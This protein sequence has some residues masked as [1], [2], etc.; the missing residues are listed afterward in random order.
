[1][2]YSWLTEEEPLPHHRVDIENDRTYFRLKSTWDL[3]KPKVD[4]LPADVYFGV[5]SAYFVL[6]RA[7]VDGSLPDPSPKWET[8]GWIGTYQWDMLI[9]MW[10]NAEIRKTSESWSGLDAAYNWCG[11]NTD[12]PNQRSEQ[13]RRKDEL[14]AGLVR[15]GLI[16]FTRTSPGGRRQYKEL[17]LAP[18][19]T[20][21]GLVPSA[22]ARTFS[23]LRKPG[24]GWF[25]M[26]YEPMKVPGSRKRRGAALPTW[27]EITHADRRTLVALYHF[28]D[29][30]TFGAVDPN[31]LCVRGSDLLL[32]DEFV[33]ACGAGEDPYAACMS[34]GELWRRGFIGFLSAR[35]D[36]DEPFPASI[37]HVRFATRT[38]VDER[39][40]T[41]LV[42]LKYVPT[43]GDPSD[44][45]A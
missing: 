28:F 5:E 35:F 7:L 43:P 16:V 29:E 2:L 44:V 45:D 36:E 21:G 9:F 18:V 15:A 8:A 11:L 10:S 39:V 24:R 25:K 6:E 31:H 3:T 17:K 30:A 33:R 40:D 37:P 41:A 14:F 23:N 22:D 20:A 4:R 26:A 19:W 32:S 1:M 34:L 12:I 13:R 27:G 42:G 38:L